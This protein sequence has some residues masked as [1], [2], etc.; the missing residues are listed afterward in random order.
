M[1]FGLEAWLM[2]RHTFL[3]LISTF[4]FRKLRATRIKPFGL[5]AWII[6]RPTYFLLNFNVF[7]WKIRGTRISLT[8]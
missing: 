1:S 5:K 3:L 8:D 4:L 6:Q 7:L 2:E